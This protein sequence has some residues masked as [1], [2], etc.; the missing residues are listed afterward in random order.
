MDPWYNKTFIESSV[1]NDSI[2]LLHSFIHSSK[3]AKC[4]KGYVNFND[5]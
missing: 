3:T 2:N 5:G 4:Q 1:H